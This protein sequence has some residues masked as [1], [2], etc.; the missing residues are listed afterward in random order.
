MLSPRAHCTPISKSL[1]CERLHNG[2]RNQVGSQGPQR[3]C[4]R[5]A[6]ALNDKLAFRACTGEKKGLLY[7]ELASRLAHRRTLPPVLEVLQSSAKDCT[8]VQKRFGT[9]VYSEDARGSSHT[10]GETANGPNKTIVSFP[11]RM[12]RE[13]ASFRLITILAF[14]HTHD[15]PGPYAHYSNARVRR[16][17]PSGLSSGSWD[18]CISLLPGFALRVVIFCSPSLFTSLL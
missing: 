9:V 6:A 1:Q 13:G 5:A 4:Y 7:L 15:F 2:S 10:G 18:R 8:T 11:T 12:Q 14:P 17:R 16:C 3:S